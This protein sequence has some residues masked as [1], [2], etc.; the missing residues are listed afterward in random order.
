[1]RTGNAPFLQSQKGVKVIMCIMLQNGVPVL[2]IDAICTVALAALMLL[3]GGFL[4]AHSSLLQKYC[5][6]VPVIGGFLAML[7]VLVCHLAGVLEFDFDK[8][9]LYPFMIA[10]FTAIGMGV[11]LK[12]FQSGVNTGGKLLLVYWATCGIISFCQNCIGLALG[13][14]LDLEPAYALLASAISMV[15]GHGAAGAYGSTFV[16]MGYPAA[17]EVGAAS[18]TLGLIFAVMVGGPLGQKLIERYQLRPDPEQQETSV[19]STSGEKPAQV[20][21]NQAEVYINMV[22]FLLCMGIGTLVSGGIGC[23]FHMKFP[24]YIGGMLAGVVVRFLNEQF[25]WYRYGVRLIGNTGEMMLNLYLAI[26]LMTLQVWHLQGIL[27]SVLLIVLGQVAFV[28]L[29]AYFLMFRVLGSNYDAAIMCAG[30]CGHGLGA[31]PS[32]LVN[33]NVL[34]EKYGMSQKAFLIVPVVGSC[35]L[36]LF[37]QTHTLIL[38]KLFV[39]NLT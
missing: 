6:P 27:G 20:P 32:A 7:L 24:G 35:L 31:M 16:S 19:E 39:Q 17:M 4:K 37:Y 5:L 28:V 21:L 25:H 18:A 30:F 10:F 36:D 34:T 13:H 9:F 38:I 12:S 22:V 33:M 8:S 2:Q 1:M 11:N 23:L 29:M 14:F 3:L 26:A 15:G